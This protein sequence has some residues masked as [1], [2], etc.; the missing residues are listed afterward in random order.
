M[1]TS[2]ISKML[3]GG[4]NEESG[5]QVAIVPTGQTEAA[6]WLKLCPRPCGIAEAKAVSSF[7]LYALCDLHLH[8]LLY[9][10]AHFTAAHNMGTL[11]KCFQNEQR[12]TSALAGI[13]CE[14]TENVSGWLIGAPSDE[15]DQ[16]G[17]TSSTLWRMTAPF[18]V[19]MWRGHQPA[20][21]LATPH[22]SR[23]ERKNTQRSA[24]RGPMSSRSKPSTSLLR[25]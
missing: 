18:L 10:C 11:A 5:H 12:R 22:N 3:T 13:I 8:S 25:C 23:S 24:I 14:V 15:F 21:Y 17:R 2:I 16:T 20:M 9:C 6:F 1:A 19:A 7:V 4:A